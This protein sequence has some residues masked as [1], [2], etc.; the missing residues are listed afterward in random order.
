LAFEV[1]VRGTYNLLKTLRGRI[2]FAS[3]S[4]VYG[5][6]TKP[7]IDEAHAANPLSSYGSTKFR[8]EKLVELHDDYAVFRFSNIYGYGLMH[9]RTVTDIFIE[10]ALKQ[11]PLVI[12]GDGRQRRDFVHINDALHA[13]WQ[14]MNTNYCGIYNIGGNEALSINDIAEL[15][16]KQYR[17]VFGYTLKKQ[18][19]P[20]DCGRRWRDFTYSSEKAKSELGYEPG[21]SVSDEIRSRFNA[22][23]KLRK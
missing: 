4:A 7:E 19:I 17:N 16:I 10:S 1:N 9:K 13:Y 3:T 2:I 12:H 15:V 11:Q 8:A 23:K 14:A 21:Y 20:E 6:A 5:E 22:Y 18:Y